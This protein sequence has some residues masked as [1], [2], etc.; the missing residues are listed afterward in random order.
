L[1]I[2]VANTDHGVRLRAVD[3]EKCDDLLA[4]LIAYS[5]TEYRTF[6]LEFVDLR[7]AVRFSLVGI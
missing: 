7:R 4:R 5:L 2:D 1:K 6:E 3:V